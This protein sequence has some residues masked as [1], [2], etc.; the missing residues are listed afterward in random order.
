MKQILFPTAFTTHSRVAYRYAQK[1]A[2]YFGAEITLVHIYES[3]T[4][5]LATSGILLNEMEQRNIQQSADAQ[6]EKE[7]KKLKLFS[8]EMYTKDIQVR[9]IPIDFIVTDGEVKY[10]LAKIQEENKFD[11]IV[12]G[13]RKHNL[14][15]RLLGKVTNHLIDKTKCPLLLIPPD[16]HY[17]GI[18]KMIYGTAFEF[19]EIKSINNLLGWCEAFDANL[20]LLH[21]CQ[22]EN[23][24]VAIEKMTELMSIFQEENEANTINFQVLEGKVVEVMEEYIDFTSADLLAIHRRKQ[25]FWQRIRGGSLTKLLAEELKIPLLVLKS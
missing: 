4:V 23:R 3:P 15:N 18:D 13:M 2:Q 21:V 12:M 6:W 10:E 1:L 22:K 8:E 5:M 14:S 20:H 19:G 11:L 16:A 25:G 7:Y 9:D 24:R 17:M